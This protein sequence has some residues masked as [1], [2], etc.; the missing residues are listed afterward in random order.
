MPLISNNRNYYQSTFVINRQ[1]LPS[2]SFYAR[3]LAE[4]TSVSPDS[5]PILEFLLYLVLLLTHALHVYALITGENSG[6]HTCNKKVVSFN[7]IVLSDGRLSREF[8]SAI[9]IAGTERGKH[10]IAAVCNSTDGRPR[11]VVHNRSQ[12]GYH[13]GRKT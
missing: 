3:H 11:A 4:G 8:E 6:S 7:A 13:L 5:F 9:I 2:L 12:S 10:V 1:R